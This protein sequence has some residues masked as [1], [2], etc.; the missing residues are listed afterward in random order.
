MNKIPVVKVELT[1]T[2]SQNFQCPR[3]FDSLDAANAFIWT[4][5]HRAI[6]AKNEKKMLG[7]FKT[8]FTLTFADSN[9]YSGRYDIGSDDKDLSSHVINFAEVYGG[10]R[11]PAHFQDIDWEQFKK[12]YEKYA[13]DYKE[14]LEKYK[15]D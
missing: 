14:F 4:Q 3:S 9:T 1:F 2:E 7:Y 6:Q 15:L 12:Q 10:I 13:P 11:K 5:N 8:D